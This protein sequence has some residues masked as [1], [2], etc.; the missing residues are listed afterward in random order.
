MYRLIRIFILIF[1][2]PGT[3]AWVAFRPLT[4]PDEQGDCFIVRY[5]N[6]QKLFRWNIHTRVMTPAL[7]PFIN[8]TMIRFIP[9]TKAFSF[10]DDGIL[11][12][13]LPHQRSA[14][15]I[16]IDFPLR[17]IV[18]IEWLDDKQYLLNAYC[19]NHFGIFYGDIEGRIMPILV[20]KKAD[21]I[22][23]RRIGNDL[24]C[25]RRTEH[26]Q[27][28]IRLPYV[29]PAYEVDYSRDDD[30]LSGHY[31]GWYDQAEQKIAWQELVSCG[32]LPIIDLSVMS[33]G[34]LITFFTNKDDELLHFSCKKITSINGTWRVPEEMFTFTIAHHLQEIDW[35]VWLPRVG[36]DEAIHFV[37]WYIE[38]QRLVPCIY[39]IRD[40]TI[41]RE[42]S[43]NILLPAGTYLL[44]PIIWADH[45]LYGMISNRT[46][47]NADEIVFVMF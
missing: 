27:H 23:A 9:H 14:R 16:D 37:S 7:P 6:Q 40:Q 18:D 45:R 31:M 11:K 20:D 21:F 34:L 38:R 41:K 43:D 12:I 24:F 17:D 32:Q 25:I 3:S 10:L 13:Q 28:L 36:T 4:P 22:L 29:Q 1:I 8:P 2:A 5:E 44:P 39:D 35:H 15:I 42:I 30:Y 46:L 33:D 26:G 19:M 47:R